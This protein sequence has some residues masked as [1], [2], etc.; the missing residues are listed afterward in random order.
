MFC[1]RAVFKEPSPFLTDLQLAN[2]RLVC[3]RDSPAIRDHNKGRWVV[4]ATAEAS[5]SG[6]GAPFPALGLVFMPPS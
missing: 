4:A 6:S 5:S 2:G 3:Q 1:V